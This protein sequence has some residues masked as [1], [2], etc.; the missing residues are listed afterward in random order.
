MGLGIHK[1][2]DQILAFLDDVKEKVMS[3]LPA[4][5][6]TADVEVTGA[7]T[8]EF[9]KRHLENRLQIE[10]LPVEIMAE[11]FSYLNKYEKIKISMVNDRWFDIARNEI[12][13]LAIRWPE[14]NNFSCVVRRLLGWPQEKYQDFQNLIVRFPRLKNLE[15]ATKITNKDPILPLDSF[16]NEFDGTMEF[17]I[18]SDLIQTKNAEFT[19][20]ERIKINPAK[21]KDFFEYKEDKIMN[22][23]IDVIPIDGQWLPNCD[24]VIEEVRSLNNVSKIEY[25]EGLQLENLFFVKLVRGILSRPYLKQIIFHLWS[26]NSLY[27]EEIEEELPKNL[28]VEEITF[29]LFRKV[30]SF[31]FYKKVLDALP[32]I[33][34]VAIFNDND[35]ENLPVFL[36]NISGLKHL[37]SLTVAICTNTED[38]EAHK[39]RYLRAISDCYK[40][41]KNHFPINS[42]VVIADQSRDLC[43]TLNLTNLIEK[44]RGENPKMWYFL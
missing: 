37:K 34:K 33:K 25:F 41:I 10:D 3:W 42:E 38:F 1:Y 9:K 14:P 40:V 16:E 31:K 4:F 20:I 7:S 2:Q 30:N 18:S 17:E 8:P 39:F 32:N 36:Q 19:F 24:S 12:K 21:E 28:N 35:W 23:K 44:K 22:F 27:V 6:S 26:V 43:E 13:T 5:S 15:L 29:D 11:I